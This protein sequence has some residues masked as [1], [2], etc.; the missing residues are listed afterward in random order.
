M[1]ADGTKVVKFGIESVGYHV[2]L[3]DQLWR[4][5]LYFPGDAV[6][7]G[8]AYVQLLAYPLQSLVRSMLACHLDRL[9]GF[10]CILQLNH[11]ARRN[12][13][14]GYFGNDTLQVA[15]AMQLVIEKLTEFRF[16]EEI[17]H[18]V[19]ALVDWFNVLQREDQPASEHTSAHRRYRTV[20][21]IQERR[22]IFLHRGNQL[23]TADGKPVHTHELIF[24]DT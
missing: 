5:G 15:D 8:L 1:A 3:I 7:Q 12:S 2:T 24:F 13:T 20:D 23:Q 17:F 14:H 6:F 4:I 18:D 10:E 9:D 21:D 16:L 11:F 22:T 19:E